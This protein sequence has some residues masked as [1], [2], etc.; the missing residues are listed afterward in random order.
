MTKETNQTVSPG[1]FVAFSYRLTDAADGSLLFEAK[2]DAPDMMVFGVTREIVP[3]L[4]GALEGLKAGD[5]FEVEL[6]PQAA[7]G[8]HFKENVVSLE[9]QIFER[10]GELAD[11]VRQGAELTMMTAEGYPVRGRVLEITDNTVTMDFNHPFAG[12][13][14]IFK[15][16]V[17]EVRD[18]T[19]EELKPAHGCGG[20]G[21]GSCGDG[22]GD[23]GCGDSGC[24]GGSCGGGGCCS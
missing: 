10:D 20:C 4:A 13:T 12:R 17:E 7:F 11:E 18:A 14:V 24:G 2:P 5:R 1:K 15:G 23:S 19:P 6:P 9:R 22:C 8:E 21:G 3:G 16:E